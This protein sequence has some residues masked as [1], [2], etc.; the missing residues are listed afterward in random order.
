MKAYIKILASQGLM[1]CGIITCFVQTSFAQTD[2]QIEQYIET[3]KSVAEEEMIRTGVPAAI[4]LAQGIVE[5]QAGTGWLATHANN[6]F[7]IKCKVDWSGPSVLHNDDAP[8]ECFRAYGDPDSSWRD[9]SDFLRSSP[10]YAPLF[11]LDPLDYKA[12]AQ[13]L[14]RAGYATSGTYAQQLINTIQTWHLEQYSE[15]AFAQMK[16]NP[17]NA[18]AAMLDKKVEED[19]K[20][21][22]IVAHKPVPTPKEVQKVTAASTYPEGLFQINGRHV[23]FLPSGTQLI[24]IAEK[25]HIRLSRLVRFNELN[26]DVLNKDMLIYLQKKK[27]TG[28]DETHTVHQGE[29]W[30]QIA[31]EEGIRLKWL[32]KRNRVRVDEVLQPGEMLYLHGYA[33]EEKQS[34]AD[35]SRTSP[36]KKKNKWQQKLSDLLSQQKNDTAS[37]TSAAPDSSANE[38]ADKPDREPDQPVIQTTATYKVRRGDTLY[39]I[40]KRYGVT[41]EEIQRWNHID[42]TTIKT[43][44]TLIISK[45]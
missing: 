43:G 8:N 7:G 9:H 42:G 20:A 19:R 21:M 34:L 14:K 37:S 1:V 38:P 5:S 10:R 41:V 11:S 44:Q 17:Q 40:S 22:G 29:T 33:P 4:S 39:N 26:S 35:D 32:L 28:A 2:N 30:H 25:Y 24:S 6:Q 31:Q 45:K 3:Y 36:Q 16:N 13:G 12:W 18:F 27:K 23:I 15:Q